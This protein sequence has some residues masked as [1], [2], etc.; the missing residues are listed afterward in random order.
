MDSNLVSIAVI[1]FVVPLL[2]AWMSREG[3][4]GKVPA[5]EVRYSRALKWGSLFLGFAPSAGVVVLAIIFTR[6]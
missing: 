1:S 4:R 6:I 5:G 2:I 3:A